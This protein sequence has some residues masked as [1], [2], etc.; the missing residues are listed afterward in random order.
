MCCHYLLGNFLSARHRKILGVAFFRY[1]LIECFFGIQ[2]PLLLCFFASLLL[3][4][5][6]SLLLCFFASLLLCFSASLRLCFFAFWLLAFVLALKPFY[7][8][9]P[10]QTPNKPQT[11]LV[12]FV[13][14]G[15]CSQPMCLCMYLTMKPSIHLE[16]LSFHLQYLSI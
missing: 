6:A 4:F 9:E 15:I 5:F 13:Y 1:F 2:F 10:K 12:I 7:P 16:Y 3:C 8:T 11:N 14:V